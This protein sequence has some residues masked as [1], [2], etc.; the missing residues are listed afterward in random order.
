MKKI[1][2]VVIN[3]KRWRL[4]WTDLSDVRT[5]DGRQVWGLCYKDDHLIEIEEKIVNEDPALIAEVLTHEMLH[6][7]FPEIEEDYIDM[8]GSEI[9]NALQRIGLIIEDED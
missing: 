4:S 5:E 3:G 9:T 1:R 7:M 8:R 2:S 6:A